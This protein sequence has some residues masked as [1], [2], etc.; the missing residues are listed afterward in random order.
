MIGREIVVIALYVFMLLCLGA[1]AHAIEAYSSHFVFV[2]GMTSVPACPMD[3]KCSKMLLRVN[4]N[5]LG[6]FDLWIAR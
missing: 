1:H 3:F 2:C 5:V 4:Y 6:D